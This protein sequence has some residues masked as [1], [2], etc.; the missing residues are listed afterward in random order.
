MCENIKKYILQ[1]GESSVKRDT[2][3]RVLPSE[4]DCKASSIEQKLKTFQGKVSRLKFV[5][6]SSYKTI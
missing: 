3:I 6:S 5:L 1:V 2:L 4:H